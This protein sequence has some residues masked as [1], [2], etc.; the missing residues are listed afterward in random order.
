MNNKI[1]KIQY[2]RALAAIFVIF[3]HTYTAL[4]VYKNSNAS[5]FYKISSISGLDRFGEFGVF[6]FFTI[7]GYIMMKTTIKKEWGRKF[8]YDFL[9]KRITRI[10]PLYWLLTVLML[11]VW[12][13]GL[14]LK[15]QSYTVGYIF[16]SFL[17]VPFYT[18]N[19][20]INPI[21]S[22]GWTLMYEMF[23]Y[24]FFSMA[25]LFKIKKYIIPFMLFIFIL[26]P[27]YSLL[28]YGISTGLHLFFNRFVVY[29]FILGMVCFYLSDFFHNVKYRFF[30]IGIVIF[31]IFI[32]FF[33]GYLSDSCFSI[34]EPIVIFFL[35]FTSVLPSNE[36]EIKIGSFIGDAS[37]SI[38][39]THAFFT[40]ALGFL[41]KKNYLQSISDIALTILTLCVAIIFGCICYVLIEKPI[42][43]Y[44]RNK[45]P[46]FR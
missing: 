35:V 23:F 27:L 32:V 30:N 2:L 28:F 19:G 46:D 37:Y 29:Y 18:H 6:L 14:F 4:L 36:K 8:A 41:L 24:F 38:Y 7:S 45:R 25:I 1:F 9:I 21:I 42:L 17:L 39:L 16:S 13:S 22:Q 10:Y 3:A 15:N 33:N 40:L 34:M 26:F 43:N 12:G 11:I 5:Y 44:I 31:L 20:E